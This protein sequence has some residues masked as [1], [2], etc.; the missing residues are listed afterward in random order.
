MIILLFPSSKS[1]FLQELT[2]IFDPKNREF[3][4]E[5]L[6]ARA[7]FVANGTL[8][9]AIKV[10]DDYSD[11]SEEDDPQDGDDDEDDNSELFSSD[12]SDSDSS[13]SDS[14]DSDSD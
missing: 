1:L 11:D 10:E 4:L 8:K 12:S 5:R 6:H 13:D 2:L 3:R 14:S 9:G 7:S